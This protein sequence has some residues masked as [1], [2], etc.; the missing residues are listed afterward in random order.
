MEID[1]TDFF[2]NAETWDYSGSV[3]THGQNAAKSTWRAAM[4]GAH[5]WPLLSTPE[6]LEAF[7]D[8]MRG[9]GAWD[10][11]EIQSWTI[12]EC[13]ALF[14][15]LIAGDMRE[16]GL[17]EIDPDDDSAWAE[18]QEGAESG[19]YSGSIFRG[20]IDGSDGYG[21]IFYYLGS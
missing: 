5:D 8:H 15:Q 19:R 21:R 13:N 6:Q 17:D 11:E 18:Y 12:D 4:G 9:Y 10:S 2:R 3:A 7:R 14:I 20:D 1:I 16:S